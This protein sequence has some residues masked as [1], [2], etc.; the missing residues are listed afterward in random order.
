M[1]PIVRA[2]RGMI[3]RLISGRT[4]NSEA[5]IGVEAEAS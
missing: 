3:R 4:V 1:G 2:G 5:N